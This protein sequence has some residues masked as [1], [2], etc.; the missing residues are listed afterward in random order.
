MLRVEI[1]MQMYLLVARSTVRFPVFRIKL[2][3][4]LLVDRYT[5]INV[6]P[7]VQFI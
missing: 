4:K 3:V 5:V 6:S 1:L 2:D 7:C